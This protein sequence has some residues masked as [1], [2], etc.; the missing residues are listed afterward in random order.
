MHRVNDLRS[1]NVPAVKLLYFVHQLA[2]GLLGKYTTT[3]RNAHKRTSDWVSVLLILRFR[4]V[5]TS[6]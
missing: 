2:S 4:S 1:V 6:S 3:K 5:D